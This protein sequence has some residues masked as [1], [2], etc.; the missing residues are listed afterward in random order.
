MQIVN[1]LK[2]EWVL[3][4]NEDDETN[5]KKKFENKIS[6]FS[7]RRGIKEKRYK[8]HNLKEDEESSVNVVKVII[9][10]NYLNTNIITQINKNI[11]QKFQL[12]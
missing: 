4:G 9:V 12:I 11:E 1:K 5:R 2:N 10:C 6:K 8:S 3:L 7:A